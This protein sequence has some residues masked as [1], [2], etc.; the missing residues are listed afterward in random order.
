[1]SKDNPWIETPNLNPMQILEKFDP[2]R[3]KLV[4][5][6]GRQFLPRQAI[7]P[8]LDRADIYYNFIKT[9]QAG[10]MNYRSTSQYLGLNGGIIDNWKLL[11]DPRLSGAEGRRGPSLPDMAFALT[12]N[13]NL[14]VL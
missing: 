9:Y 3:G 4:I 1:M 7:D 13:P 12:L 2:A 14:K 11:P 10:F 8:S 5:N 6:D